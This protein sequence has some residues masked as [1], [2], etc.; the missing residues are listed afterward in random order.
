VTDAEREE[1]ADERDAVADERDVVAEKYEYQRNTRI[2]QAIMA[3][4]GL[5]V[6]VGVNLW[7]SHYVQ[8]QADKRWCALMVSLDDRYQAI[9]RGSMNADALRFA[10]QIHVLRAD[11]HCPKSSVVVVP[12]PSPSVRPTPQQSVPTTSPTRSSVP[13]SSGPPSSEP[14]VIS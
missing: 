8:V 7:Y 12:T 13:T 10:D 11:F 4:I 2:M 14:P 9:P 1:A 3:L 6:L 5:A